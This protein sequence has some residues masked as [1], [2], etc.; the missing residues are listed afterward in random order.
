MD[1][2]RVERQTDIPLRFTGE[3]LADLSSRDDPGQPRW[4]EIRIYR[5]N[6]GKYVT[7]VV[8]QTTVRSERVFR[9]VTVLDNAGDVR[10]A[11]K[12]KKGGREFLNDMAF[13][14]LEEAGKIDPAIGK[15]ILEE[16][17]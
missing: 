4:Q 15:S 3:L 16:V 2:F 1:E 14:A 8:G 10:H 6:T 9:T 17:I 7:E 11:L 13:E 12:R 5:T